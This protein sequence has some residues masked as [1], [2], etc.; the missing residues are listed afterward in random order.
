MPAGSGGCPRL[1]EHKLRRQASQEIRPL[2]DLLA[3]ELNCTS[4]PGSATRCDSGSTIST[5]T[6]W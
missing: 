3:V 2:D 1:V 5:V 6:P 4:Q